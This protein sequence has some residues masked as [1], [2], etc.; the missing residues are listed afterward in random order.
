M[1]SPVHEDQM[2]CWYS[3]RTVWLTGSSYWKEPTISCLV[4]LNFTVHP[5]SHCSY[6]TGTLNDLRAGPFGPL[7]EAGSRRNE[8]REAQ[9]AAQTLLQNPVDELVSLIHNS[10]N[11]LKHRQEYDHALSELRKS[12]VM[13][14][15]Q[16]MNYETGDI[17][18]WLFGA[19]E[20][21]M[22]LLRAQTQESLA[23]LAYFCVL[24]RRLE[25]HVSLPCHLSSADFIP[26]TSWA[27]C[28]SFTDFN[29]SGGSKA[30]ASTWSQRFSK[31]TCGSSPNWN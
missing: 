15:T 22:E 24:M 8:F 19:T 11:N 21:F 29:F 14:Y 27:S 13:V 25:H 3:E 17:F 6:S 5:H 2:T 28:A 1:L 23:I 4:K 7:F 18:I 12:F 20:G 9:A 31:S 30:G 16:G 10:V 26:A